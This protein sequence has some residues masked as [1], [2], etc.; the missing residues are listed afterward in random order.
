MPVL[1][2]SKYNPHQFLF[3]GHLQ[4]LIP[5]L[6]RKNIPLSFERERINTEDGDFLDLDWLRQGSSDLVII[7]HGL[8][9]NSQRPYMSGMAD[10]FF[11]TGYDVLNWNF[12]GC[13]GTENL[14]RSF[15]HS[16]ATWDLEQV[17]LHAQKNY[18]SIYLIGFSLGGNLTLKY[19]GEKEWPGHEKIKKAVSISVPLDLD[20]SC[21]QI[22]HI[23]NKIYAFNFLYSLKQKIRQ[24][25]LKFPEI[26][27]GKSLRRINS[28]R[29]FDD[30]F[31][32][33]L[34]GFSQAADYYRQCSAL[35]FLP[36]ICKPTLVL[37]ARNDPFLSASCYPKNREVNPEHLCLQ[38]PKQGGHV[39][40]SPR[41]KNERY[42]SEVRALE[43][44]QS[45]NYL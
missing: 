43:F 20:G 19:L 44:I 13:S 32:A 28:L 16:G 29:K 30:V 14:K 12:R 2:E 17:I 33:P 21:R 9:G 37:N 8:E 41:S 38:Y 42:W 3:N 4:T 6:F 10:N 34:H 18:Q 11:K 35:Q 31:T 40:F 15:Y 25:A 27:F 1:N 36:G 7:S 23:S 39:G 24:K 26:L 22:D 5:A 45:E